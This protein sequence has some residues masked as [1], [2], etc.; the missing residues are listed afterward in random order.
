MSNYSATVV[1]INNIR[2][3]SNADRLVCTNIFGNNVIVG[4]ETKVGDGGLFFPL[5]SQIGEEFARANDLIRRKDENGKSVGGMFDENRRV[6]AQQFRGEKSM[7]FWIPLE[8]SFDKFCKYTGTST[9]VLL[10]H[11]DPEGFEIEKI[12]NYVISQKYIPPRRDRV[13][14][15]NKEGRKPRVSRLVDNQFRFHFDTAQLGKNIHKINTQDFVVLTWKL[16][17]TSAIAANVLV[18]RPLNLLEKILKYVVSIKDTRYDMVY[19]SRRVVKNEFEESKDHFYDYDLWSEVGKKNFE[20]KLR[21]GETIYYEIVGFT[22][23]GAPIQKGYDYGCSPSS[24]EPI[25]VPRSLFKPQQK[26]FI[27]RITMTAVDGTVTELQWNQVK[28]RA[29]ELDVET[30]PE[31]EHNKAIDIYPFLRKSDNWHENLLQLLRDVYVTDQDSVFCSTKVPE[32]GICLRVENDNGIQIY[33]LKSFRFLEHETKVLDKG[34]SNIEDDG[35]PST[36]RA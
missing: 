19:A 16:H 6:R 14:S 25:D 17:G 22:K 35:D 15:P 21:S 23:D 33:K 31:I 9:P 5:E 1:R 27:Y 3:H 12:D 7:G 29:R 36:D 28:A 4:K 20:G 10:E 13:S 8:E 18:K 11:R 30:V 2:P 24:E 34:E 32:E 26:L